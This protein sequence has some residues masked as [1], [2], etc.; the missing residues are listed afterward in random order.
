VSPTLSQQ[1]LAEMEAA[2]ITLAF[3]VASV[4]PSASDG[5]PASRFALGPG[6]AYLPGGVFSAINQ[7][8]I[9]Y[10]RFA[11]KLGQGELL[12]LPSWIYRERFDIEARSTAMPSKDQM[13]LMMQA[14]LADRFKMRTHIASRSRPV[15][16]LIRARRGRIGPQLRPH[17]TDDPCAVTGSGLASIPCG[18]AGPLQ[19]RVDAHGRLVGRGV[20][21]ARLAELFTSPFTGIDR[22]IRDRTELTGTFDF[23]VE[24]APPS[25]SAATPGASVEI[26]EPTFGQALDE[27]LGLKLKPANGPVDVRIVDHIERPAA[28]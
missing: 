7:P 15:F 26:H 16:D 18:R 20:P 28:N 10:M 4:K 1:S 23:D 12:G 17:A 11:F 14:L 21:V 22:P 6:D 3:E 8:L 13:R 9:A 2:G 25:D 19:A 5:E 24:W 27:Q